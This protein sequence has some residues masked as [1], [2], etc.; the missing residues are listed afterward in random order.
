MTVFCHSRRFPPMNP[1]D[2]TARLAMALALCAPCLYPLA[3]AQSLPTVDDAIAKARPITDQDAAVRRLVL[4]G[5]FTLGD[6]TYEFRYSYEAPNH[7]SGLSAVGPPMATYFAAADN[8]ALLYD[9]IGGAV[10][11][12]SDV[13]PG[14]RWVVVDRSAQIGYKLNGKDSS[15]LKTEAGL[16]IDVPSILNDANVSF[17][18]VQ[19]VDEARYRLV[20]TTFLGD[21]I[22]ATFD[23]AQG[24][25]TSIQVGVLAG[26]RY[27]Q[28]R[29]NEASPVVNPVIPTAGDLR[30]R[31]SVKEQAVPTDPQRMLGDMAL[32]IAALVPSM[33][34]PFELSSGE[35]PD[36][37]AVEANM[38][39]DAVKLHEALPAP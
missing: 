9:P 7:Y 39:R 4:S 19:R 33:R 13:T 18:E 11:A 21:P 20:G 3:G 12:F 23:A 22:T 27:I 16:L 31:F 5:H 26:K 10:S 38:K 32:P 2:A 29:V 36:W 8:R 34:Q 15:T 25:V 28:L 17:G 1:F 37:A 14:I 24:L 35:N 6:A 30:G